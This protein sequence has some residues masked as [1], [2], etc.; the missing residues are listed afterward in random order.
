MDYSFQIKLD[1]ET[2]Y[3]LHDLLSDEYKEIS[4]LTYLNSENEYIFVGNRRLYNGTSHIYVVHDEKLFFLLA[5][6]TGM[7]YKKLYL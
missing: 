2:N 4:G 1:S 6:S 3:K 5:I 7:K